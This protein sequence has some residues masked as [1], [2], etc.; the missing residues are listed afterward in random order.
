MQDFDIRQSR[1]ILATLFVSQSFFSA[2]FIASL[3]LIAI[4][5]A[6]LAGTESAAGI[7][8][9]LATLANAMMAFPL[10]MISDR[11]GRRRSVATGYAFGVAGAVLAVLAIQGASY[12]L[13]LLAALLLG[14][15]RSGSDQTRFAAAEVFPE[16]RRAS[17]IGT[18]VFAGTIGAVF[19]PLL[20]APSGDLVKY[21][22]LDSDTGSYIAAALLMGMA[23]L[24]SYGLLR[25]DPREIGRQLRVATAARAGFQPEPPARPLGVIFRQPEVQLALASMLV[26][27]T[28]MVAL[29]VITPLHM[30][31][32]D[33]GTGDISLVIMAHTLGMFGFSSLTGW[34]IDR[35]GRVNMVLAGGVL[36]ILAAVIAPLSAEMP[37][38]VS[39][40]F[41]LGLG[42]NFCFIGGS[43]LLSNALTT[44]ERGRAQG[45]NDGL[46]AFSAGMG[47]LM[48]GVLFDVGSYL[49]VSIVALG[50]TLLLTGYIGSMAPRRIERQMV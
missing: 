37:M 14:A 45:L 9:S 4:I 11:F 42:W 3:T 13:F 31:H 36:L 23:V 49:L 29:M 18:I 38:L 34:L 26:G 27:Q 48:S 8:Q 24:I 17:I 7:P 50:L 25:P 30:K 10:G 21:Y 43:S 5:S 32:H 28:V 46:V 33:H 39:A 41:L 22:G 16:E 35:V 40:L 1:R 44:D 6:D 15:G 19:G 47:S 20:V 2:A 12:P